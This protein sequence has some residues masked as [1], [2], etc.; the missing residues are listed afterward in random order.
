MPDFQLRI[1]FVTGLA[2][3]AGCAGDDPD[4][5]TSPEVVGE[6]GDEMEPPEDGQTIRVI[7]EFTHPDC[8]RALLAFEALVFRPDDSDVAD[9]VC[10][11]RFD[12]GF[13]SDSCS[14]EHVFKQPGV[15]RFSVSVRDP[16]TGASD[17][18]AGSTIVIAPLTAELFA[19][20]SQ[21]GHQ[22]TWRS[23][24][25]PIAFSLVFITPAENVLADQ[26]LPAGGTVT[27][28][29]PGTYQ[30]ELVAEDE[31]TTGPICV[32]RETQLVTVPDCHDPTTC[33]HD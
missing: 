15:H 1:S 10:R 30:I 14:G 4:I 25:S 21:C 8:D 19:E 6:W 22:I 31:R 26:P 5:K 24:V 20:A 7:P 32:E 16:L 18:D 33:H 13:T 28:S 27:V 12:D 3:L 17:T 29:E 11:W 23:V 9:P 2:L